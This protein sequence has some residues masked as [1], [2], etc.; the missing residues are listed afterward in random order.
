M[1]RAVGLDLNGW[2]DFAAREREADTDPDGEGPVIVDGGFGGVIVSH[3]GMTVGGPQ[4]ILSPIGRGNGWSDIGAREKRRDLR[5][6]WPALLAGAAGRDALRDLPCAAD[7]LAVRAGRIGVCIPDRPE[8]A[9]AA[10]HAILNALAGPRR[11]TATLIWRS[12]ALALAALD[13]GVLPQPGDGM[14]VLCVLHTADGLEVQGFTLRALADHPGRLA[15]ERAGPGRVLCPE[16]GL[17]PLLAKAEAAVTAA[18][19][20]FADRPTELPRLPLA[21][22]LAE[23]TPAE[24][25][26]IRRDNGTWML[27]HPPAAFRL[28][29]NALPAAPVLEPADVVLLHSPLAPRHLEGLAG[30][31]GVTGGKLRVMATDAPAL[32]ALHAMRRIAGGMAHYLD[33]LDQV[34]LAVLRQSGPVFEDLI[35]PDATVPG[36][37]EYVSAPIT[38]MVWPAEMKTVQFF[39]RKGESAGPYEIRTWTTP[40]LAA[41]AKSEP[42]DIRLRQKPAQGWANLLITA[43]RWDLL[44]R[45]PI[46]LEWSALQV[47][48]RSEQEVLDSLRGPPPVVPAPVHYK[49]HIGLWNGVPGKPRL[50]ALLEH[51]RQGQRRS[52]HNLA[53]A[54]SSPYSLPTTDGAG[55]SRF[56]AIGTDG[57][58]PTGLGAEAAQLFKE[59]IAEIADDLMRRR[60]RGQGPVNN[61]PLRCLTWSF[62]LCPRDIVEE[63]AA[64]VRLYEQGRSHPWLLQPQAVVVVFQGLGRVATDAALLEEMIPVLANGKP[65]AYRAGALATMLSRPAKTPAVLMKLGIQ[66]LAERLADIIDNLYRSH[67]FGVRLK[68]AL[69]A[70]GGLLRVRELDPWALV[71]TF[72]PIADRLARRLDKIAQWLAAH[73]AGAN[74]AAEKR[75]SAEETAKLLRGA[76]GRPDILMFVDE[77]PD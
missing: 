74:A 24:P 23:G 52:V 40:E 50:R 18:N 46:R 49:A 20:R 61:D 70:I 31:L 32:G 30:W 72:S 12:V 13:G 55:P 57:T 53:N 43:P 25:E 17:D 38:S 65:L 48:L 59:T 35:P 10:R 8:M 39:V 4:A 9:E 36:N 11:P 26:V 27:M 71:A 63:L 66:G 1:R 41:P 29:W 2:R 54:L 6:L 34:A 58:L 7:A 69:L 60:R 51:V 5:V 76:G 19:P 77:L 67:D 56:Y 73:P 68:Y 15:P 44:R 75:K 62:A 64:V 47:D 28:P 22:L 33:R 16:V 45:A 21:L 14:R 3:D 37:R 42:L